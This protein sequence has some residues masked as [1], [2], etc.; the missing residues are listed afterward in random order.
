M[1]SFTAVT[2][3]VLAQA[4][5]RPHRYPLCHPQA[6]DPVRR[7]ALLLTKIDELNAD[8]LC[9]QEVEPDLHQDLC[10]RLEP[11]HHTAYAQR[12]GR[13]DGYAVFARRDLFGWKRPEV[14]DV[15]LIAHLTMNGEPLHVACTHLKWQDE[16]VPPA[17]HVG[18]HQ[19]LE[20]IKHRDRT[21]GTWIFAGDFNATSQ[22][23][24]ITA[25]LDNGM[26]ESCRNQRPWDTV[27]INGRT[28]KLDYLLFSEGQ[29][30]PI[31]GRLPKLFRDTVLPSLTEPSDHL[32]VTVKLV[33]SS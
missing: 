1:Q 9:L 12:P 19:M 21:G 28:R 6:L 33:P 29:F 27:A 7:R 30:V 20:L 23:F 3:N 15:A 22:S 25:A 31:P 5:V 24:V 17:R 26:A 8:L 11:T 13:P 18:Y 16:S 4:H 2:Y 32:P 10:E 14:I